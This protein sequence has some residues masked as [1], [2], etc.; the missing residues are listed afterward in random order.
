MKVFVVGATG[1]TGRHVIEQALARGH[2]VVALT[3]KRPAGDFPDVEVVVGDVRDHE[4]LDAGLAGAE[5][6]VSCLGVRLGQNPGSVRSDGTAALVSAM[7]AAAVPRLVAV[8]SVGVGASR[9]WQTRTARLLWPLLVGRERLAE[10]QRAEER[11]SAAPAGLAWT[12]VRPPKLTDADG[13]A[14]VD[15][16]PE[17]RTRLGSTLSRA[18]LAG[19]LLDQLAGGRFT[20]MAVTAVG[21]GRPPG[22]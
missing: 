11:I 13:G 5:A 21:T 2:D 19:V 12:V 7:T 22:R 6:V 9:Q 20:G 8:S 14:P 10:A 3:R 4:V 18:D 17:V 1:A 16:G 15:V